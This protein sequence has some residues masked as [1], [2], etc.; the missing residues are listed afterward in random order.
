LALGANDG[1]RG[2]PTADTRNNLQSIIAAVKANKSRVVLVSVQIPPNYGIDYAKQFRELYFDIAKQSKLPP[3]P[4]LLEGLADKLE[5]FQADRLHP[6]AEAQ[7]VIL[8]N[9]LPAIRQVLLLARP[10]VKAPPKP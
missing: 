10:L 3:P 5:L 8:E 2:L 7:P 9:V 6:R 4:F 1:L